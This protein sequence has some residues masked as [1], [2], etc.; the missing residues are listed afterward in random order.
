[1]KLEVSLSS[2]PWRSFGR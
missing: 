2:R 1:M